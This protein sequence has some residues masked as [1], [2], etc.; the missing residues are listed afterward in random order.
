[1]GFRWPKYDKKVIFAVKQVMRRRC[2]FVIG[3]ESS[4]SKLIAR[5]CSH[6]LGIR[7]FEEWN[8]TGWSDRGNDKL[9]HRS[10]PFDIP[11]KF[12]DIREWIRENEKEYDLFFILTTRDIT[13]SEQSRYDRWKKP[14]DQAKAESRRARE[15]M[16]DVIHSGVNYFIWSYETFMFLGKDYLQELYAFL[17]V[18]SDFFPGLRDGNESR[19]RQ[20]IDG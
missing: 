20:L 11:P 4:G 5:V 10:L 12:P 3:P 15:I 19:I 7:S 2:V 1:M 13:L 16:T 8:G 6:A 9:C 17:G 14:A 18:Q